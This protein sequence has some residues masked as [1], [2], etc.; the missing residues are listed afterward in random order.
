MVVAAT[1]RALMQG[2]CCYCSA[3]Y[4][5]VSMNPFYQ[6]IDKERRVALRRKEWNIWLSSTADD[7]DLISDWWFFWSTYNGD[8]GG[9]DDNLT[10]VLFIFSCL[11]SITWLLELIQL[12]CVRPEYSW[13]WLQ[14]LIISVEDIPQVII[15][16]L[17]NNSFTNLSGISI[18]NLMTS[19][20][21][22]GIRL[23]GELFLNACYCCERTDGGLPDDVERSYRRA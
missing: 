19:L 3:N 22:L 18:F 17:L 9:F 14:L 4:K 6:P 21:S 13:T 12:S 1:L 8:R 10:L 7:L 11:G 16:L 23:A 15:T 2:D 5:F 20:Y